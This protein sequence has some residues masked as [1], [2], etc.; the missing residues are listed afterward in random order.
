MVPYIS[1]VLFNEPQGRPNSLV[2]FGASLTFLCIFVYAWSVG[3]A[4]EVLWVLFLI[5]GTG[6]SGIAESLPEN[7]RQAAGV[8]R[9]AGIL[10][11]LLLLL[12]GFLRPE[13]LVGG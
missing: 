5:V 10:V 11:L 2:Q 6:L 9:F 4:G 3:D 8:L 13:F 1:D 7:R 12:S